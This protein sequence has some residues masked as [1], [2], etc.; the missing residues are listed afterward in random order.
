MLALR[1]AGR[2]IL[3]IDFEED[4]GNPFGQSEEF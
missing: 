4:D 3:G 2:E 1:D